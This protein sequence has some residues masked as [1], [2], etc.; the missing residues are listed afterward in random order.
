MKRKSI[1]SKGIIIAIFGVI[2]IV[3]NWKMLSVKKNIKEQQEVD[4]NA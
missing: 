1:I 3:I 2:I 4:E